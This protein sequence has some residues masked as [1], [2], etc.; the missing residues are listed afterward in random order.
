MDCRHLPGDPDEAERFSWTTFLESSDASRTATTSPD[1]TIETRESSPRP[2]LRNFA[3]LLL[4]G[5]LVSILAIAIPRWT[6]EASTVT[7]AAATV[8]RVHPDTT[9]LDGE[10]P[11]DTRRRTPR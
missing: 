6:H 8:L 7:S 10:I 2:A 5:A 9:F 3:G 4:M 1:S 11:I